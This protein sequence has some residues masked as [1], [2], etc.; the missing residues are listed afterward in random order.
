MV[1]WR[2]F[3]YVFGV[4]FSHQSP[5]FRM[6]LITRTPLNS[7]L[8]FKIRVKATLEKMGMSTM[9]DESTTRRRAEKMKSAR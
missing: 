1:F 3:V 9:V 7:N 2:L 5:S 6:R 8:N 4:F